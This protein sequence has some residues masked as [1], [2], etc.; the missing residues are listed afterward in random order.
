[1]NGVM[2]SDRR[3]LISL[4]KT[5]NSCLMNSVESWLRDPKAGQMTE[6]FCLS[7]KKAYMD[8]MRTKLPVEY[9]NVQRLEEGNY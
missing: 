9:E 7:E 1:M 3:Q 4:H 2:D 8:W 6:D 5:Y